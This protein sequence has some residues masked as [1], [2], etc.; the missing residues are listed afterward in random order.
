MNK[1]S[2]TLKK[3]LITHEQDGERYDIGCIVIPKKVSVAN[4]QAIIHSAWKEFQ[5]SHPD[6]D[7][8]FI[9]WLIENHGFT[10]TAS[11]SETFEV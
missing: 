7:D 8:E 1:K 11:A 6:C 2:A 9:E 4:A 10:T 3:F 5:A